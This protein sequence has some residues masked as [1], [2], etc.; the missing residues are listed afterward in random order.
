MKDYFS[1]LKK[2]MLFFAFMALTSNVFAQ[3]E[4]TGQV[5]DADGDIPI[6]GV[7]VSVKGTTVA[8]IT[9][10]NG[11]FKIKAMPEDFIVFSYIGYDT[12]EI[13]VGN[14]TVINIKMKESDIGLG[15]VVVIGYGT[16]KKDDVTGS[17]TAV[18]AKDFNQGNITSPQEL[19]MGKASGVVITAPTGQPGAGT[20]IRIRG[21][22][23]LRANNE[24]LIVIDG[25][26]VDN[27]DIG[28]MSNPLTSINPNDIE[29]FTVLKDASAT[30]IYGSRASNGVIIIT[31]KQGKK[32]KLRASYNGNFSL[33]VPVKYMSV[34]SGDE[35]RN[36]IYDR[37]TNYGLNP[38]AVNVLGNADTDWQ[39]EIYQNSFSQDHNASVSGAINDIVPYRISLGYTNQNGILKNTNM[40]RSTFDVS[41][42]PKLLDDALEMDINAKGSYINN[43]F[44]NTDAIGSAIQ[45]DPSQPIRN[46]NTRY[47]GYTAWTELNSGDPINGAPNNIATHNPLAQL[48]YRDNTSTAQRYL[49]SGKF[50]YEMPFL[51]GLKATANLGYDYYNTDG[52]DITDTLASWSYREPERQIVRYNNKRENSLLNFYLTYNK[53][54]GKH[55]LDLMGGYEWQHYYYEGETTIRSWV[56]INGEY[57]NSDT[58]VYKNE[59]FLVSFLGRA[60]YS[61][62]NKYYLTATVRY[63]GSS[64]FA[65]EN[66]WG[67]FPSFAA[68]WKINEE[69]FMANVD[70]LSNL[71]LRLGWG[72]TGQQDI[73]GNQFYPYLPKYTISQ[74][75]A[76]YQFGNTFY[77]TWRPDPYDSNI[78]W[79][80]TT[81][82]NAGLDF[83]FLNDRISGSFNYYSRETTD[84]INEVPIAAGTNFSNRLVTNVGSLTNK[85]FEFELNAR[86]ISNEIISWEIGVNFSQ[87]T[88]KITKLTLGN[89]PDYTGYETGS[90]SGGVGNYVQVNA[91]GYPANTFYLFRQ[92]YDAN[93]MPIEGLYV[94]KTG[95]GGD[96]SGDNANKYYVHDP[97]PDYLIGLSSRFTYKNFDFS[98]SGRISIGN[99]VYNNNASSMALYQNVY[100]QSGYTANILKDVEKTN[101][102]TAQYWSDFYLEN[103]SFFR[104]D[105]ISAGYSFNKLFTDKITG[106]L[107]FTVQNAFVITNY[108]GIDPEV[109]GGIDNNIFPRPR[110]FMLSLNLNF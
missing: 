58:V 107:G 98:F 77:P 54:F 71:K 109:N 82:I 80:E 83:G 68:A 23:S 61:F 75:G 30:A 66:R 85:G 84:L 43:D 91:V 44:S 59:Y 32:G 74:Q 76:Y 8:T 106:R 78:K 42:N 56:P 60:N 6:P 25:I 7:T 31:T 5:L 72:I 9:D 70:F 55:H 97:A 52:D 49:L 86:A 10:L 95:N 37:V 1:M 26:P 35:F 90:I 101:F 2:L 69:A 93:G 79:E 103:A 19:L 15:E 53:D 104:M 96:V 18:S 99:Y 48:E 64:R 57:I 65:K 14:Q 88:N 13:A 110:T 36:L 24:P 21:G 105:N 33:G 11:N 29:T 108:S 20:T 28:G 27:T 38:G 40:Q 94:D 12:Q 67:L 92:V 87:N 4:I 17:V 51:Q 63:D 39:K 50:S 102:M 73:L 46:G 16:V 34:F 22:S 81:T 47:G 89:D 100:N 41:V 45:F 3:Q 62:A